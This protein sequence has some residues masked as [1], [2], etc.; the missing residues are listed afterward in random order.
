[1]TLSSISNM[2]Y[3]WILTEAIMMLCLSLPTTKAYVELIGVEKAWKSILVIHILLSQTSDPMRV[4]SYNQMKMC[5][6]V[7]VWWI[8]MVANLILLCSLKTYLSF[9]TWKQLCKKTEAILFI[10]FFFFPGGH[11]STH[12]FSNSDTCPFFSYLFLFF[13]N[14][15]CIATC[16][17]SAIEL[18]RDSNKNLEHLFGGYPIGHIFGVFF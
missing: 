4:E 13:M 14:N 10:F 1:M 16:F 15:F 18:L 12:C 2:W 11:L 7:D 5:M 17:F 6:C 8:Y 3:L 9:E